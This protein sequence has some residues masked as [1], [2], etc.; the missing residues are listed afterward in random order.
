MDVKQV[1]ERNSARL[2]ALYAGQDQ[3]PRYSALVDD[4]RTHFDRE[5]EMFVSAPGRTEV[6]GNHT[7][8]QNGRVLAGAVNLDTVAAIAANG[9]DEVRLYSAGYDAPFVVDLTDLAVREDEK[10][11]TF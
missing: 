9:K 4:F 3:L 11:T 6:V 5:P 10:N 1:F 7:D 8:H 2:S